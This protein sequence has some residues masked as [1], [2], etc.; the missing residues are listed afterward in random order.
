MRKHKSHDGFEQ[1]APGM[2]MV[3]VS[4]PTLRLLRHLHPS[5]VLQSWSVTLGSN[6]MLCRIRDGPLGWGPMLRSARAA[7]EL[8]N[9]I[10]EPQLNSCC[11][12]HEL[13]N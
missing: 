5:K 8:T 6:R 9:F 12:F 10:C 7:Q 2:K 3:E 11:K 13:M 1:T 4:Q